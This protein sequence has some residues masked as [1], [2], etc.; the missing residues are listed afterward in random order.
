[1]PKRKS[2]WIAKQF[3]KGWKLGFCLGEAKPTY[4]CYYFKD[5]NTINEILS[6]HIVFIHL[7]GPNA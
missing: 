6:R 7:K 4:L 2:C 3:K 5:E 1:M